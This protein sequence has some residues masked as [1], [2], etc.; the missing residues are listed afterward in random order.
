MK[1][2]YID[3]DGKSYNRTRPIK[4]NYTMSGNAYIKLL[5]IRVHLSDVI[6]INPLMVYENGNDPHALCGVIPVCNTFGYYVE[7]LDTCE[8][9]RIYWEV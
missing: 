2:T 1:R 9:V 8:S 7:I 3:R 5:G 6:R 4:I